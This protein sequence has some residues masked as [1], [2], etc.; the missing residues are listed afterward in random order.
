[1][2]AQVQRLDRSA[3]RSALADKAMA[4][5]DLRAQPGIRESAAMQKIV[6]R[7]AGADGVLAGT[8]EI[9]RVF[10]DLRR[11]FGV[12]G[13]LSLADPA[14]RMRPAG[15]TARAVEGLKAARGLSRTDPAADAARASLVH[16]TEAHHAQ[17]RAT[18]IGTHYGDGSAFAKL[19][20]AGKQRWLAAHATPGTP[21]PSASSLTSSSCIGWTMEHV[22]RWYQA[23]GKLDRWHEVERAVAAENMTGIAL[24]RELK[25]DGWQTVLNSPDTSW[26]G[27]AEAPDNENAYALHV[28]KTQ[29][30]YYGV[31]VDTMVTDWARD[32]SRL[33]ALQ[34]APFFVHVARGGLHVT[35]GTRGEISELARSEGPDGQG[36]Y[37]DPMSRIVDVYADVYGGGDAGRARAMH[38]WGSGLTLVPPGSRLR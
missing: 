37:Q 8:K 36:I 3:F 29:G 4:V 1:M 13:P 35:A 23:S 19:D 34:K 10:D 15:A 11:S 9:D 30:T 33:A 28:A 12:P 21:A 27:T 25:K 14:L 2:F 6:T 26:A 38:M 32:P 16:T 31:P 22:Q 5:E 24:A 20:D 18:G 7:A 17:R